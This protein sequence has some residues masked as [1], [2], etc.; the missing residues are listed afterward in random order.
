[1]RIT[2]PVT[3]ELEAYIDA[4]GYREHHVLAECRAEAQTRGAMAVMQVAPEQ[5]ALLQLLVELTDAR[6][7]LEIGTFTGYSALA[8]A[9]AMP[10]DGR[11]VTLDND[12][13][14]VG[15]A[16]RFWMNAGVQNKIDCQLGD[17]VQTLKAMASAGQVFDMVLIDADKP[18]YPAYLDL[19]IELVRVGGLI[20]IDDTLIHGRV[21]TGPLN[22]DPDFVAPAVEAMRAVNQRVRDDDRLTVAMIPAHDGLTLARRRR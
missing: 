11:V 4:V 16:G 5:G 18:Q 9:L 10:E 7:V 19:A 20:I 22:G 8:M 13:E 3:P 14:I 15:I 6:R 12:A 1:M 17:A 21:V 2:I